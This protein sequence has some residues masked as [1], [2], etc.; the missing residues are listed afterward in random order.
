MHSLE[1]IL[2]VDRAVYPVLPEGDERDHGRPASVLIARDH[3]RVGAGRHRAFEEAPGRKEDFEKPQLGGGRLR[4][5]LSLRVQGP[6]VLAADEIGDP[7][8]GQEWEPP[9]STYAGIVALYPDVFLF[10]RHRREVDR[11][12]VARQVHPRPILIRRAIL[13]NH[14]L[15]AGAGVADGLHV[16]HAHRGGG[17][18]QD[19][20]YILRRG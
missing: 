11:H 14:A 19:A 15:P 13:P 7:L 6:S 3:G 2:R 9:A 4:S 1:Q 17:A 20:L 8:F 10:R 5:R 16:G 18:L 12:R